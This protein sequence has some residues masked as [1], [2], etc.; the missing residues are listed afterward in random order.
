M[1]RAIARTIAE[2]IKFSTRT[3]ILTGAGV[4]RASG[5]PVYR[6]EG[7]MYNAGLDG[8]SGREIVDALSAATFGFDPCTTWTHLSHVGFRMAHS[9]PN[10]GHTAITQ[11]QE[12]CG[13]VPDD[14]Y[15][16]SNVESDTPA[17]ANA[18]RA[19]KLPWTSQRVVVVT[20]NIDGYHAA[21]G[22]R[23]V[24]E[25]HGNARRF[26]CADCGRPVVPA[27]VEPPPA[28]AV[29]AKCTLPAWSRYEGDFSHPSNLPRCSRCSGVVRPDVVLFGEML[30]LGPLDQ[31]RSLKA[32]V[33]LMVGSSAQFP[34]ICDPYY[35][36]AHFGGLTVNINPTDDGADELKPWTTHHLRVPAS[37][38][39]CA[40]A[41]E[42]R[43]L[44]SG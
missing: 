30:P 44:A 7:G 24:V 5:L 3:L 21:A 20:Q 4:S 18:R 16:P 2:R 19:L 43:A 22:T 23:D 32:D 15:A 25:I 9:A 28:G 35:D 34:Y 11:I 8:A 17:R 12:L 27:A 26:R 1:D 6:G 14:Q 39:L 37:E 40:V 10:D 31:L 42:L 36:T 41:D 38:G 33:C 29:V 13:A